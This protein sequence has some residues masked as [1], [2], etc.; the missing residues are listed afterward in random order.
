[1]QE[2]KLSFYLSIYKSINLACELLVVAVGDGEPGEP[3]VH[4]G[5]DPLHNL[6]PR[7]PRQYIY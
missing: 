6:R 5:P 1:M 4:P 3:G 2:G 7:L